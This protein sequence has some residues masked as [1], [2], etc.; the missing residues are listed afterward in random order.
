MRKYGT[1]AAW[2]RFGMTVIRLIISHVEMDGCDLVGNGC[3][4]K[5]LVGEHVFDVHYG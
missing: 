2:G 1:V 3:V 5:M 4:F